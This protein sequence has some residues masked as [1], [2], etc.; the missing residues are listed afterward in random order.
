MEGTAH[1]GSLTLGPVTLTDVAANLEVKSGSANIP[2]FDAGLLGGRIHAQ[3]SIVPGE[4]PGYQL[5]GRFEQVNAANLGQLLGMAWTGNALDGE[6]K[7]EL[8][9]FTDKDLAASAKGSLHFD[10][11][12]GAIADKGDVDVPQQLVRFD[13]W[14][15][16]AEIANG[17]ITLKENQIQRGPRKLAVTGSAIFGDPPRVTFGER[18]ETRVAVGKQAKP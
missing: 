1:A 12:H 17:A 6:G 7:V 9:G 5:E 10:W 3:G 8:A 11:R 13:R 15:A 4:K 18:E 16:E 14:T 2:S